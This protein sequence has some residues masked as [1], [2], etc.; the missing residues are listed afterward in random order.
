MEPLADAAEIEFVVAHAADHVEI[1]HGDGVAERQQRMVG[2]VGGPE[3][4]L[5]F[6]GEV[7]KENAAFWRAAVSE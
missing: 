7:E 6:A 4:S 5:L 3:Q 1:D 2:V